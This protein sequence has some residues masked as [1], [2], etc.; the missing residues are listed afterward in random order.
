MGQVQLHILAQVIEDV[1]CYE[2]GLPLVGL[3]GADPDEVYFDALEF[4]S[5]YPYLIRK[6]QTADKRRWLREVRN[7]TAYPC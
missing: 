6:W 1:L 2:L 5:R 4:L 3:D 7:A